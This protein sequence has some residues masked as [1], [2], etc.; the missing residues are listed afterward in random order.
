MVPALRPSAG[1]ERIP[2]EGTA[3]SKLPGVQMEVDKRAHRAGASRMCSVADLGHFPI[4]SCAIFRLLEPFRFCTAEAGAHQPSAVTR[5][6]LDTRQHLQLVLTNVEVSVLSR[7]SLNTGRTSIPPSPLPLPFLTT[8]LTCRSALPNRA[9]T[10]C[11]S[12]R[13]RGCWRGLGAGRGT[14]A[15]DRVTG[16]SAR[17]RVGK[18]LQ[19]KTTSCL[20][21]LARV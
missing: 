9:S 3:A 17:D 10:A 20:A 13:A 6:D 15:R 14:T 5:A 4:L 7:N 16:T 2:S 19:Y 11:F 12:Q 8:S 18:S 21:E 1:T